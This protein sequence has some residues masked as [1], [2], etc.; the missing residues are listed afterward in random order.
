MDDVWRIAISHIMTASMT[1]NNKIVE[2]CDLMFKRSLT[3]AS[4]YMDLLQNIRRSSMESWRS[5][6]FKSVILF[7]KSCNHFE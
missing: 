7:P 3:F 6:S 4:A 1:F 2:V 5:A